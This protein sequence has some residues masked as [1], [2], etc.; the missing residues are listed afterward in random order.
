M[1][2][3]QLY[4]EFGVR[5]GMDLRHRAEEAKRSRLDHLEAIDI[6]E[7]KGIEHLYAIACEMWPEAETT[8]NRAA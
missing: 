3:T 6:G 7:E 2:W 4:T 5:Y 1:I 8:A